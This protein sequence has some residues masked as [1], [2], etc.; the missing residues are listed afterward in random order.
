MK[1]I[2]A[3][4]VCFLLSLLV[5]AQPNVPPT[6]RIVTIAID[7]KRAEDI[8]LLIADKADFD[9]S[10]NSQAF[11]RNRITSLH[12]TNTT[13]RRTLD[14]LFENLV[15]YKVRGNH[16]L[17]QAAPAPLPVAA[18]APPKKIDYR[19]SGY[20]TD[21]RTGKPL[22][23]VSVVDTTRVT[24]VI[25]DPYGFYSLTVPAGK[26]PISVSIR[27]IGYFDTTITI[28]PSSNLV[29]DLRMKA[30]PPLQPITAIP[31]SSLMAIR[32]VGVDSV[33]DPYKIP[34]RFS[35]INSLLSRA[36]RIQFV[37]L[38]NDVFRGNAQVSLM[39]YLSTNGLLAGKTT[40]NFSFNIIAG[41]SGGTNGL[42]IGGL[43]NIDRG[44]VKY[45]QV[46]GGGNIVIGNL[47]GV[48]AAGAFNVVTQKVNGVQLAGSNNFAFDSVRGAQFAGTTN[49]NRGYMY[50]VQGSGTLN[51]VTGNFEGIQVSGGGNVVLKHLTGAQV[52]G[53]GN[54]T[55]TTNGFQVAGALN[56]NKKELTGFQIA[57]GMNLSENSS[58]VQFAG[59]GNVVF[60]TS[61]GAQVAGL[62]NV[63]NVMIGVQVA[64]Y[65][66]ASQ[67]NGVQL[68]LVNICDSFSSGFT[69]GLLSVVR[70]G[71]HQLEIGST[72]NAF[73]TAAFRTGIPRFYN[74]LLVGRGVRTESFIW[75]VGYGVGTRF[76]L[77]KNG[78]FRLTVDY[79]I[80][81][82]NND[83]WTK[84]NSDWHR[85]Q[86]QFEWAPARKF[87]MAVGP[88]IN[89]YYS[90]ADRNWFSPYIG[91]TFL[92]TT[93]NGNRHQ[94]WVGAS[95]A[96]RFL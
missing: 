80:Q 57:G 65:N 2:A 36:Q 77:S 8:F 46:A 3:L 21:E 61:S 79:T 34:T 93:R 83:V 72:E 15:N 96:V 40:N 95:L 50:G 82:V 62:F 78:R 27:H 70:N 22:P 74:I 84:Y 58:G 94:L 42:E 67:V 32:P 9:Y 54:Y 28:M 17:L 87:S 20:I 31:D 51:V 26:T 73:L 44:D 69:G 38:K 66:N 12:V 85:L 71:V 18:A 39:P 52:A 76:N 11:D 10:Y 86:P 56:L 25:S 33:T 47:T 1:P 24:A 37:N 81:H 60:D 90:K 63:A 13:V 48:Q 23:D 35:W 5:Q 89:W 45:V 41:Y 43:L 55:Q 64:L 53:W 16:I 59:L 88:T 4:L 91:S 6:E 75:T 29:V 30:I 92:D 68:G 7:N 19:I 49:I 14:K